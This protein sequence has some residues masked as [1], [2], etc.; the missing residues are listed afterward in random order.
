MTMLFAPCP[1]LTTPGY[2]IKLGMSGCSP[3]AIC[4][5]GGPVHGRLGS[6]FVHEV[7]PRRSE[8]PGRQNPFSLAVRRHGN[9]APRWR[10]GGCPTSRECIRRRLGG[11]D[12][13]DARQAAHAGGSPGPSGLDAVLDDVARHY[14]VGHWWDVEPVSGGVRIA[15]EA[16]EFLAAV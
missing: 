8:I 2:P 6:P 14:D 3:G 12:R 11:R 15:A 4:A 7:V 9:P 5:S 13:V 10:K 1:A 16:G